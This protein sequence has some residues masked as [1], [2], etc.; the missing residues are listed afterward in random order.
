M[1]DD[2][3]SGR[4]PWRLVGIFLALVL[5][6]SIAGRVYYVSQ[7]ELIKQ[8]KQG[9]LVAI[10]NL[11]V[12]QI[13]QW[14]EERIGDAK[15]IAENPFVLKCVNEIHKNQRVRSDE[16]QLNHW[17]LSLSHNYGYSRVDLLD[18]YGNPLLRG[19]AGIVTSSLDKMLINRAIGSRELLFSDLHRD[20]VD[21]R[22][23]CDIIAPCISARTRGP[24]PD[25]VVVLRI[26]ASQFL[27]PLL[28]S[29]PASSRTA[30]VPTRGTEWRTVLYLNELRHMKNTPLAF[31]LPALAD[32]EFAWR[33]KQSRT[34]RGLPK[35][36]DYRGVA[37]L[38]SDANDSRVLHGI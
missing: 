14:R 26:D 34:A 36:T 7:R 33:Q 17:L 24:T 1:K 3:K 19:D 27:F 32:P 2:R 28:Q 11:K 22:I 25:A 12:A 35:G 37:V 6:I 21:N 30:E 4:I 15:S 31:R 13:S 9:E 29:W 23:Y 8:E 38:G 20:S 5:G 10:A 16:A 18:A